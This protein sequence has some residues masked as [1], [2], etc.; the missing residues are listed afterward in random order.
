VTS[1]GHRTRLLDDVQQECGE[2][3]GHGPY[4]AGRTLSF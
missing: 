2:I 1:A 4:G 3:V